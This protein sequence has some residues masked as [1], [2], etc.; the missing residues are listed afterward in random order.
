MRHKVCNRLVKNSGFYFFYNYYGMA[1]KVFSVAAKCHAGM[2]LMV[3]KCY[4]V[5]EKASSSIG[6][7]AELEPRELVCA[8]VIRMRH[9]WQVFS[10]AKVGM[11]S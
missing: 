6:P 5:R 4:N 8:S 10:I 7:Q 2:L 11:R 9:I 3:T 1:A